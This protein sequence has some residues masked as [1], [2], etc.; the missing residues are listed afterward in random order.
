MTD[1]GWHEPDAALRLTFEAAHCGEGAV[2]TY[3]RDNLFVEDCPVGEPV[4][5]FREV[6]AES[7]GHII[8]ARHDDV[9]AK[10]GDQLAVT[11]GGVGDDG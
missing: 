2:V 6:F 5:A 9:G 11:I 8:T 1:P 3:R 7:L 4:D 10:G